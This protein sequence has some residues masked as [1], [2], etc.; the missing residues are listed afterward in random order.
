MHLLRR[1]GVIQCAMMI[2]LPF[3]ETQRHTCHMLYYTRLLVFL[4]SCF[5]PNHEFGFHKRTRVFQAI[6]LLPLLSLLLFAF[7]QRS[8]SRCAARESCTVGFYFLGWCH[9]SLFVRSVCRLGSSWWYWT[10]QKTN[11]KRVKSL[12]SLTKPDKAGSQ[13]VQGYI[14]EGSVKSYFISYGTIVW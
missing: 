2:A 7:S 14:R 6:F 13:I 11:Q 10:P 8:L 5:A 9:C 1:R 12:A 3:L 4:G